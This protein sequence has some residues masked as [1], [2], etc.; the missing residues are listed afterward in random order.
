M[1]AKCIARYIRTSPQ[2]MRLLA[3]LVRGKTVGDAI[4]LLKF[5]RKPIALP[6]EK[7]LKSAL[8]NLMNREDAHGVDA[9]TVL[10]KEINI[11]DGPR[12]KRWMPRAL[13]RATPILKRSCH[14]FIT[15][16]EDPE[17]TAKR[18]AEL[19]QKRAKRVAKSKKKQEN[20]T[21]EASE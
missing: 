6:L 7:A 1:E 12:L 18:L 19:E 5:S 10:I 2:K 17:R 20:P 16:A 8:S 4:D 3:D 9:D 13:G 21:K 15:V 14:L 11:Q